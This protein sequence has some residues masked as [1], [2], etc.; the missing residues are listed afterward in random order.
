VE[1]GRLAQPARET[2]QVGGDGSGCF[3]FH[4]AIQLHQALSERSH[5]RTTSAIAAYRGYNDWLREALI[6]RL[7]QLPRAA[8]GHAQGSRGR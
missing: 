2:P 4:R 5:G 7:D 1:P 8:I 6:E 3:V